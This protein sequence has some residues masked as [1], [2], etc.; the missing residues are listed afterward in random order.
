MTK[1]IMASAGID[2]GKAH[3][4]IAL[5]PGGDILQVPNDAKGHARLIAWLAR[6]PVERIGIE[7]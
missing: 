4:D 2:T 7:A 6:H 3:L 1:D 5:H